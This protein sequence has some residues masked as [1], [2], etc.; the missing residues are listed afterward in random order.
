M[1][2]GRFTGVLDRVRHMLVDG[3]GVTV[4]RLASNRVGPARSY[5]S[6]LGYGPAFGSRPLQ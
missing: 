3:V 1:P 5:D 4:L 2:I 6:L